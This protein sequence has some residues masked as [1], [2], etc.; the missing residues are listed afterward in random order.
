MRR[1][2]Q[3]RKNWRTTC[4][5]EVV[6]EIDKIIRGVGGQMTVSARNKGN[7]HRWSKLQE[8]VRFSRNQLRTRR[9]VRVS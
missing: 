2:Y 3:E 8:R 4:R 6:C 5:G 1:V 7:E 9:D